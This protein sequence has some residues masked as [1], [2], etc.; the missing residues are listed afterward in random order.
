MEGPVTEKLL[1]SLT[2]HVVFPTLKS[3]AIDLLHI[4][5]YP[6]F[7]QIEAK[8]SEPVDKIFEVVIKYVITN[9]V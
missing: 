4:I 1:L 2:K 3:F 5:S 9:Q 7:S 8:S 6:R